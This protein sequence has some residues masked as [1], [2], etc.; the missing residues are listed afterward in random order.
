VFNRARSA[1]FKRA[2]FSSSARDLVGGSD[3]LGTGADA[4]RIT[5]ASEDVAAFGPLVRSVASF[6]NRPAAAINVG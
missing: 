1:D 5:G 3:L 2:A 6:L 4:D